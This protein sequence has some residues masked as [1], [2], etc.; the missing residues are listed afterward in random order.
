MHICAR[1][2]LL[3][4]VIPYSPT[5]YQSL[6]KTVYPLSLV[7]II[8]RNCFSDTM[9][10]NGIEKYLPYLI[11]LDRFLLSLPPSPSPN[12]HKSARIY[13]SICNKY[14]TIL[15]ATRRVKS[16][17]RFIG[18]NESVSSVEEASS[19]SSSPLFPSSRLSPSVRSDRP[20]PPHPPPPPPRGL[21]W[22]CFW[23][24]WAGC[25][26]FPEARAHYR[27]VGLA[28][29][30]EA[31]FLTS[32]V[33]AEHTVSDSPRGLPRS[34]EDLSNGKERKGKRRGRKME[35]EREER[36]DGEDGGGE[37]KREG[38]SRETAECVAAVVAFERTRINE[39]R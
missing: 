39:R 8:L 16:N 18:S 30:C 37:R 19:P 20:P 28:I 13:S 12:F 6:S 34:F 2:V 15:L 17:R 36:E 22:L 33:P 29:T 21:S 3:F 24:G 23:L 31:S 14:N 4:T 1:N 10:C 26:R 38:I 5:R 7:R 32:C 27:P 9:I 35:R 11:N 25:N